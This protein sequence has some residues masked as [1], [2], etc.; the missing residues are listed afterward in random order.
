MLAVFTIQIVKR[1]DERKAYCL[2]MVIVSCHE[3]VLREN[4]YNRY[5]MLRSID[6]VWQCPIIR[7]FQ[8]TVSPE[9]QNM[10]RV[11]LTLLL[12][13]AISCMSHTHTG[14][15]GLLLLWLF[16]DLLYSCDTFIHTLQ[17]GFTGTGSQWQCGIPEDNG[18]NRQW[19]FHTRT[20][21]MQTG[22]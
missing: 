13:V 20:Q 21:T 11:H 22:M 14:L 16:F 12:S 9:Q 8:K 10:D 19:S 6:K 4:R 1:F 5:I 18:K 2:H 15:W 3:F 7:T 17:G